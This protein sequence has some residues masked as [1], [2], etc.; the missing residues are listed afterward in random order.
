MDAQIP[1]LNPANVQEILDL[2]LFGWALSRFTGCW[3][4]LKT[5]AETIDSSAAVEVDPIAGASATR[6]FRL[7]ADGVHIRWPDTPLDQE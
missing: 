4:G 5:I 6:R 2:G 1:V 3:V 7:P